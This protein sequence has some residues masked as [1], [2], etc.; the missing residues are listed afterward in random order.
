MY[1]CMYVCMYVGVCVCAYVG[2]VC[3]VRNAFNVCN[4]CIYVLCGMYVCMYVRV[5][6]GMCICMCVCM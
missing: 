3:D 6:L 5:Y 1:V 2:N 4:V